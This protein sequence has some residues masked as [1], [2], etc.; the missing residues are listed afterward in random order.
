MSAYD[1]KNKVVVITGGA[2]GMG[3][4]FITHILARG[5]LV[6]FGD[7]N[8]SLS[9]SLL[10]QIHATAPR[11]VSRL[12]FTR[13]DIRD[14]RQLDS[15]MKRTVEVFGRIDLLLCVAGVNVP[16]SFI[17]AMGKANGDPSAVEEAPNLLNIQVNLCGTIATVYS[18]LQHLSS[19]ACII[20]IAST[21]GI[22]PS[23]VQ[24]L[25]SASK[26]GLIGFARS[27]APLLALETANSPID[28]GR[29]IIVLAPSTYLPPKHRHLSPPPPEI[30]VPASP[31][32][33]A[34]ERSSTPPIRT[35]DGGSGEDLFTKVIGET[36]GFVEMSTILGTLDRTL[37]HGKNGNVIEIL[38]DRVAMSSFPET[39]E[40]MAEMDAKLRTALCGG[41]R[42]P[43]AVKEEAMDHS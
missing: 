43:V 29:R 25:Y 35:D 3:L 4:C 14:A 1:Y 8:T 11:T 19:D 5:G 37:K 26:H 18:S 16:D 33:H 7:I 38:P 22:Y 21:T 23:S 20:I 31:L 2:S 9:K 6:S 34:P 36:L 17:P 24:P 42:A 30:P 15:L 40:K 12:L 39:P 41:Q 13:T 32:F 10:L 28:K 27:L